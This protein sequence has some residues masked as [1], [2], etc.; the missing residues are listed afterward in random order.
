MQGTR[1]RRERGSFNIYLP[2]AY[3]VPATVAGTGDTAVD[4]RGRDPCPHGENIPVGEMDS[5][6]DKQVR[7]TVREMLINRRKI[8]QEKTTGN[9][10]GKGYDILHRVINP[11]KVT[12]VKMGAAS[13]K[14]Q[15]Q[16]S[17]WRVWK[18]VKWM[19]RR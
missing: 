1:G 4:K 17:A 11:E 10:C 16:E 14:A 3:C 8:K 13:A 9:M 19:E 12:A 2:R 18:A 7:Y 15:R 5:R 6:Q